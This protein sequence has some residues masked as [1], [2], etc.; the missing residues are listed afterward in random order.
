[1]QAG[2]VSPS[3]AKEVVSQMTAKKIAPEALTASVFFDATNKDGQPYIYA[4][5]RADQ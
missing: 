2:A 3:Q 4:V 1:M 5:S